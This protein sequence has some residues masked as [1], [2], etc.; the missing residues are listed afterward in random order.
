MTNPLVVGLSYRTAPFGLLERAALDAASCRALEARLCG[1]EHVSEAVVLSTCNRLEVYASVDRFHAALAVIGG[2]LAE[3]TGVALDDL[4]EHLYVHYE[5]AAIEHLFAVAAGLDSMAVGEQQILGQVR[6]ALRA[7]QDGGTASGRLLPLL[8][9]ALRVGKRVHTET[10][11]DRAAASLVE[12]GLDAGRAVL[13]SLDRA[14]ALVLGA[15]AM[16]G[17]VVATLHRAGVGR[18]TVMN[19]TPERAARLAVGVGGS[20]RP[21]ADLDAALAEA[22]LVISCAGAS[23]YL[24]GAEAVAT[25]RAR[26]RDSRR[27]PNGRHDQVYVDLALPRD[28]DPAIGELDGVRLID[29]AVLGDLLAEAEQAPGLEQARTLVAEEVEAFL[30]AAVALEAAPTVAALREMARG[31]VDSELTRLRAR[32]GDDVD[33]RTLAEVERAVHRVVEKLLHTPSVRVK[34]LAGEPNGSVYAEALREL[35][36]LDL[37]RRV[38]AVSTLSLTAESGSSEVSL[39]IEGVGAS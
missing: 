24:V 4:T 6:A 23:G 36:G 16:S 5:G 2:L 38:A 33:V 11:I 17:L 27:S 19:R 9:A 34:E 15:G 39:T 22:D 21:L 30:V 28:I 8:Q 35:F 7:A 29:L 37:G 13:G 3:V 14:H 18:L 26:R 20:A 31:V 32:L 1:A 12:T 10:D 25:A